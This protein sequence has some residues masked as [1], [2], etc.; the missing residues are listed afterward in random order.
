MNEKDNN[1]VKPKPC[2]S[3]F[4]LRYKTR[5]GQPLEINISAKDLQTANTLSHQWC[6]LNNNRYITLRPFI[7]DIK[8]EIDDKLKEQQK[9]EANLVSA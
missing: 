9:S 1:T 6:N 5:A 2:E 3:I 8:K 7:R 4:V